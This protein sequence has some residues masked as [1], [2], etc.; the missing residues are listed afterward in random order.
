MKLEEF[1]QETL[2]EI[3]NGVVAAQAHAAEH[4]AIVNAQ[5][6]VTDDNAKHI[7]K[8]YGSGKAIQMVEFDVAVTARDGTSTQGGIGVFV[9]P[10]ALGSKGKSDVANESAS[11][12]KFTIP[13]ALPRQ[14]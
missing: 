2:R 9:G 8:D 13:I 11:R 14:K 12:V 4:K 7:L 3:I 5:A 1:V 6:A 10:V